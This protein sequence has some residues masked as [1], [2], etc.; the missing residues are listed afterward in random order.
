LGIIRGRY[1]LPPKK[2]LKSENGHH[3]ARENS[4]DKSKD[5]F[6]TSRAVADKTVIF[7]K[8]IGAWYL[9][10]QRLNWKWL[11][12]FKSNTKINKNQRNLQ[13]HL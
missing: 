7:F 8:F 6:L 9:S 4:L 11:F 13:K 2:F 3:P 5:T 1:A 10:K 12:S